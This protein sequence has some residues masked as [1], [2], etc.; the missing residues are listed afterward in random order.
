MKADVGVIIVAA[1]SGT[2][3]KSSELKQFRWV[4]GKPMLLHSLQTFQARKDVAMVVCVL[5]REHVGDPPPWI[6]QCDADR[7]LLSVGGRHRTESVANGME[8]L[9]TECEIVIVHDAA[10]PLV[11]SDTINRVIQE[12]R[13]G[14][15]AVAAIPVTDTLKRVD[16]QNRV[17]ITVERAGLWRA[18][19]P[20]GFPRKIL[21]QAH[22]DAREVHRTAHDDAALCEHLNVQIVAVQGSERA[23]KITTE[24]DFALVE[25]LSIFR[26]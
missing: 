13:A 15:V 24:S 18:Q 8:D 19:T 9:P 26:E 2:R 21:E 7:L 22:R 5:P 20:Q 10:R 3:T 11:S 25:A 14:H 1:G 23:A 12:A 4:A 17:V 6:F 16:S